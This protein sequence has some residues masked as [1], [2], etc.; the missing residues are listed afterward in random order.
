[1]ENI[2]L[3]F[4]RICQKYF[5]GHAEKSIFSS[6]NRVFF[7][8]NKHYSISPLNFVWFPIRII[9]DVVLPLSEQ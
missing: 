8:S 5:N 9:Y 4:Y 3:L 7:K 6:V 2:P 1:M